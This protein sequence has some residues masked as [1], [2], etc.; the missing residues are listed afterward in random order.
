MLKLRSDRSLISEFND[1][2]QKQLI[3][4]SLIYIV[5]C[6][7][8]LNMRSKRSVIFQFLMSQ[9]TALLRA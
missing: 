2:I 6:Q 3:R 9:N 1:R 5:F 8:K 7:R 4:S